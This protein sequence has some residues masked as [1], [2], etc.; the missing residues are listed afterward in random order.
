MAA[1]PGLRRE[2][3]L[4][5]GA[6]QPAWRFLGRGFNSTSWPAWVDG[7]NSTALFDS[8]AA[9]T[10]H[11]ACPYPGVFRD[12]VTFGSGHAKGFLFPDNSYDIANTD[13]YW[14]EGIINAPNAGGQVLVRSSLQFYLSGTT[15]AMYWAD[16]SP[17]PVIPGI[18][19]AGWL[20]FMVGHNRS[21]N[22]A[23]GFR[24]FVNGIAVGT[25][26]NYY[27]KATTVDLPWRIG[28]DASGGY[29]MNGSIAYLALYKGAG[30]I[31]DADPVG[32]MT[33]LAAE[34]SRHM[35]CR[36]V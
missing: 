26:A 27:S 17:G 12:A 7:P 32:E 24:S 20:D 30:L 8:G 31:S 29:G 1:Q 19:G 16:A 33:T 6:V 2:L 15:I 5:S 36:K 10:A 14:I 4:A 34:R 22:H 28:Q 25:P 3:W 9:P 21:V 35:R 11:Q 13:D 23:D 18:V